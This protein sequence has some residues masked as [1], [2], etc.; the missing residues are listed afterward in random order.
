MRG[1]GPIAGTGKPKGQSQKGAR[2][3]MQRRKGGSYGKDGVP[4]IN[5]IR[6]KQAEAAARR[7]RGG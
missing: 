5:R 4:K 3:R 6:R 7:R 2:A 1:T